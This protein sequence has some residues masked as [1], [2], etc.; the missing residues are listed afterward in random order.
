M[1][2]KIS[3]V[4]DPDV[5]FK[6][7][8]FNRKDYSLPFTMVLC[9][10]SSIVSDYMLFLNHSR[11]IVYKVPLGIVSQYSWPGH[12]LYFISGTDG[13]YTLVHESPKGIKVPCCYENPDYLR[14]RMD[15][16]KK[17]NKIIEYLGWEVADGKESEESARILSLVH[18]KIDTSGWNGG[19]IYV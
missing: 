8:P 17:T 12:R 7:H 19:H 14:S 18:S 16:N 10:H 2:K 3:W 9:T 4:T 5:C 11:K 13:I 6:I 15:P 1:F